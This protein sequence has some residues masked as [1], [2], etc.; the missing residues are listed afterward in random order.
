MALALQGPMHEDTPNHAWKQEH[1]RLLQELNAVLSETHVPP[2]VLVR[3]AKAISRHAFHGSPET[4]VE[5]QAI[6]AMLNRDLRTRLTR[7][8]ADGWGTG[9]WQLSETLERAEHVKERQLLTADLIA[10]FPEP[11]CLFEELHSALEE[12]FTIASPGYGSPHLLVNH[13]LTSVQGLA[14][15]TLLRS[16][17]GQAGHF[18]EYVGVAL[19]TL[20]KAGDSSFVSEYVIDSEKSSKVLAHLAEAYTRAHPTRPYTSQELGLFNRI[21]ESK[22]PT[23]LMAASGLTRQIANRSPALAIELIC[24]ADFEVNAHATH[25]MFMWLSADKTIPGADVASKRS[26]LLKK[27]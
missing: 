1:V 4:T 19:S 22:D 23:V 10:A 7:A 8:L 24:A 21:F 26:V 16:K 2:V 27:L 18:E 17:V 14:T 6:M 25:D 20:V 12:M 5:A 9:T 3:L 15:E 11:S 13:L